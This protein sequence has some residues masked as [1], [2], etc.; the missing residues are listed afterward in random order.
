MS[1]NNF[2]FLFKVQKSNYIFRMRKNFKYRSDLF[3]FNGLIPFSHFIGYD[4]ESKIKRA[5][6]GN[7]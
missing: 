2:V 6:F 4:N 5:N 3:Q 7:Q 1:G